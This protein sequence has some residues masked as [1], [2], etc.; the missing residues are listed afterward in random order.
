MW[1]H[2]I[3]VCV[4]ECE[5]VGTQDVCV[6]V[7][8][9]VGTHAEVR[10]QSEGVRYLLPPHVLQRLNLGCQSWGQGPSHAK[11]LNWPIILYS[12]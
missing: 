8:K 12:Y 5:N 10:G 3:C 11:P 7:C 2:R 4:C 1:A 9:N 6:C